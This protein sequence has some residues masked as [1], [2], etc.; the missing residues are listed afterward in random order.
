[1]VRS[2]ASLV[3]LGQLVHCLQAAQK[4]AMLGTPPASGDGCEAKKLIGADADALGTIFATL[5]SA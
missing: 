4:P 1:M 5:T 2:N 3:A